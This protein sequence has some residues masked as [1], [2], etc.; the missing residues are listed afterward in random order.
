MF[1][2]GYIVESAKVHGNYYGTSKDELTSIS[3]KGRIPLLD[4]DVRGVESI[5]KIMSINAL[6]LLPTSQ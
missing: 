3:Q 2:K 5:A 4:I 6:F 1:E